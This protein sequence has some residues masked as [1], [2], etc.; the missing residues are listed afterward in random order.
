[1]IEED[2]V[3]SQ[4][5]NLKNELK[6]EIENRNIEN[7]NW[8]VI[9]KSIGI[10]PCN[11][12]KKK[13]GKKCRK[14]KKIIDALEEI[15]KNSKLNLKKEVKEIKIQKSTKEALLNFNPLLK[16]NITSDRYYHKKIK[17]LQKSKEVIKI[18]KMNFDT[19]YPWINLKNGIPSIFWS[20]L[21][22][23]IIL[24]IDYK[25]IIKKLKE[26]PK[27]YKCIFYFLYLRYIIKENKLYEIFQ[28]LFHIDKSI[29][30]KNKKYSYKQF[31]IF[32]ITT[33]KFEGLV[34]P[35]LNLIDSRKFRMKLLEEEEEKEDIKEDN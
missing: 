16:D 21:Y 12:H 17:I 32:L 26:S 3:L 8:D 20:S 25:K 34:L 15:K 35:Q 11:F 9:A 18:L 30:Y 13:R 29:S 6:N 22:Q 2:N 5:N 1:M 31:C 10:E 27:S 19:Y 28:K 23:F 24:N 33:Y 14:C 7:A 4:F